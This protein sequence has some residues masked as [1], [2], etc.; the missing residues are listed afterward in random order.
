MQIKLTNSTTGVSK[1]LPSSTSVL[2][3]I[4]EGSRSGIHNALNTGNL[5]LKKW[6][7]R[8]TLTWEKKLAARRAAGA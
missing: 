4:G 5:Y 3:F 2:N 1:M 8:S 7:G 6:M